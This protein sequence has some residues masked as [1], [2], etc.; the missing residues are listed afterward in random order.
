MRTESATDVKNKFGLV[1]DAAL[2]EP[3][4]IQKSGRNSVV[5]IAYDDYQALLMAADKAW[6]EKATQ[7]KTKGMEGKVRSSKLLQR[8]LNAD[9]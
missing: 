5:M 8:L 7:A 1:M 6:G 3:V 9:D 2:R 4:L